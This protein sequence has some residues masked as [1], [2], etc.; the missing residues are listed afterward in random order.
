V[1][2]DERRVI[3]P[4]D[5]VVLASA[6]VAHDAPDVLAALRRLEGAIDAESMRRMNAAVD[7]DGRSPGAVAREF[8]AGLD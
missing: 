1:L 2:E 4:Y 8:L 6:R 3:P 7:R 5:A